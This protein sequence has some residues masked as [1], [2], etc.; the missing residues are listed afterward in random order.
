VVVGAVAV[1]LGW[2][3][4][5]APAAFAQ[6]AGH[7]WVEQ[8]GLPRAWELSRGRAVTVGV[9][10]TGVNADHPDLAGAVRAG[11]AFP[12][13][14]IGVS[15][16]WGHGTTVAMLIAGRGRDGATTGVAPAAEIL[17]VT[18]SGTGETVGEAIR[19]LVD[20]HVSVINLS[21]GRSP[22]A[23]GSSLALIDDALRYAT[24]HD[25]V[26][27]AAAGN[28]GTDAAVTVPANRP[29]VVAVTAVD[30]T[31]AFRADVSVAGAEVALAA[32]GVAITT[33]AEAKVGDEALSADG[34]SYSAALV[35]GVFALVRARFPSLSAAEVTHRVL[36]TA[37]PAGA[38]GRNP[39]YGFGIVDPVAALTAEVATPA[40]TLSAARSATSFPWW[41]VAGAV[42]LLALLVVLVVRR[43]RTR[44]K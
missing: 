1:V 5:P 4:A 3:T 13:L 36:A 2:C 34:T 18:T 12:D 8:L 14:G 22:A 20:Q 44:S 21:V 17:P 32:P 9:L 25:V 40:P 41:I 6:D 23:G 33:A 26:I 15:D 16:A 27:V 43:R 10:D 29:G 28:S 11:Q 42:P 7:Y 24:E 19:W 38:P 37:R 31:G 30:R 35:S 39:Q